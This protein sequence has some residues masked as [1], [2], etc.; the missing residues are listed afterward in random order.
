MTWDGRIAMVFLISYV[1]GSIP[2]AYIM[3]RWCRGIDIRD[4]GSGNMGATNVFRV[5]GKTPGIIVLLFDAFKGVVATV[6]VPKLFYVESQLAI[7]ILAGV[8]AVCGHNWTLFLKF[9]GGKGIATSLGILIGLCFVLPNFWLVLVCV[10]LTFV[11]TLLI[12]RFVSLGSL[13]AATLLPVMVLITDQP[14]SVLLFSLLISV[15]VFLRHRSNI[16]RLLNKTESKIPSIWSKK[17]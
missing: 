7:N 5:L 1:V 16:V 10:I 2:A 6:L 14:R 15:F 17:R 4:H 11:I 3:G 13:C 8:C 12:S 9:R